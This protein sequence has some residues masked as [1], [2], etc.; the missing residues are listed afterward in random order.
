M[1]YA[2]VLTRLLRYAE[3]SAEAHAFA[4]KVRLRPDD[5]VVVLRRETIETA[6]LVRAPKL[7]SD[8][9]EVRGEPRESQARGRRVAAKKQLGRSSK[10]Q[11]FIRKTK[12]K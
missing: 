2:V 4:N 5:K 12:L 9:H 7:R 10:G 3:T 6:E 11:R 8:E 1:R